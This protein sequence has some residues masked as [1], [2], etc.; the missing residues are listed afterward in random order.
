MADKKWRIKGRVIDQNGNP[1]KKVRVEVWDKD[2]YFDDCLDDDLTKDD[3]S[4]Q[5]TFGEDQWKDLFGI[6]QE[7]AVYF[8]IWQRDELIWSTKD[9]PVLGLKAGEH[10]VGDI[11]LGLP[12]GGGGGGAGGG[13]GRRGPGG[14]NG[15]SGDIQA[16]P[17]LTEEVGYPAAPLAKA[18][19]GAGTTAIAQTVDSALSEVLGWKPRSDDNKGFI[20]A[21][22]QSFELKDVEGHVAWKW[23]PRTYAVQTDLAGGIS[24]AQA[25]IYTRAKDAVDEAFPLLE[26]IYALRLDA[27]PQDSEALKAIVRSQLTGLVQELGIAGGPRVSRVDQLFTL[28]LGAPK[29]D[30]SIET[31]PDKVGGQLGTLRREFG[32]R[33][34]VLYQLDNAG[35]PVKDAAGKNIVLEEGNLVNTVDEE[36]NLTN[37]RI[38]VDYITSLRQSWINNKPFF[39]KPTKQ[40]FFGTQLVLLSRQ[41]SVIAESVD[42]VRFTLGSVFIGPA[43]RQTV[44]IE[45]RAGL[46]TIEEILSWIQGF[47]TSE[48]PALIQDGGK[49]AVQESLLPVSKQLLDVMNDAINPKNR[50]KIPHGYFTFR[51]RRSLEELASQL[52]ELINLAA[53][54]SHDIPSQD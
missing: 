32:L 47:A 29:Q 12:A 50:R 54:I 34:T 52:D 16:Y 5:L 18:S 14:S 25:S 39:V 11:T 40:P 42:E 37:F 2:D 22:T 46:L 41:L 38:L 48:G 1:V 15:A 10:D 6:D 27:D 28:L 7:L 24:G 30:G 8:N 3:G 53:P 51:V 23:T 33:T 45:T 35:Q 17:I 19:G 20:G 31:E 44:E 49:F 13:I 9:S 26:G 4:F 43:E 36:H 21:L